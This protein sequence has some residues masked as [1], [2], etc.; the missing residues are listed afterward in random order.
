MDKM[1]TILNSN[2]L[3][4]LAAPIDKELWHGRLTR[5]VCRDEVLLPDELNIISKQGLG[6]KAALPNSPLLIQ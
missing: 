5:D 6:R 4:F 3:L 2:G 1:R